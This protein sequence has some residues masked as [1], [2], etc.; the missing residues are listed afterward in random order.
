[1]TTC[2]LITVQGAKHGGS[3]ITKDPN[4]KSMIIKWLNK[5]LK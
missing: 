2:E 4:T 3:T 5:T 1:M